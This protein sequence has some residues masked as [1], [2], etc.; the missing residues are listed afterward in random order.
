MWYSRPRS[1]LLFVMIVYYV[2]SGRN[3]GAFRKREGKRKLQEIN[4]YYQYRTTE[5]IYRLYKQ[6][7]TAEIPLLSPKY[8]KGSDV[9]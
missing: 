1:G 7:L 9:P 5:K 3:D 2:C 4:V 8:K 6:F